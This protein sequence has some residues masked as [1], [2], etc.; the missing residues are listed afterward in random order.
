MN[1]FDLDVQVVEAR[2]VHSVSQDEKGSAYTDPDCCPWTYSCAGTCDTCD[3]C[4]INYP[5]CGPPE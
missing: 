5:R 3:Y 4:T 2:D 1:E